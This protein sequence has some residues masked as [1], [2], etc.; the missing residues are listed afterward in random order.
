MK[1]IIVLLIGISIFSCSTNRISKSALNYLP[2][3]KKDLLADGFVKDDAVIKNHYKKNYGDTSV[4]FH[5]P[6]EESKFWKIVI[7]RPSEKD[8][9]SV[10]E[11]LSNNKYDTVSR[12]ITIRLTNVFDSIRYSVAISRSRKM[13]ELTY[14]HPNYIIYTKKLKLDTAPSFIE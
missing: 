13:I 4:Y 11:F 9:T 8:S 14:A 7:I 5:Y 6:S 2:K 1:F 3:S 10:K 12:K